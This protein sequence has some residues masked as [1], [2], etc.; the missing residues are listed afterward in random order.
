MDFLTR[1]VGELRQVGIPVSMVE[2]IDAAQ[3][4][5]HVDLESRSMVKAAL[6]ATLVKS[7]R[8][9]AAFETAFEAYFSLLGPAPGS[10]EAA[11]RRDADLA[12]MTGSGSTVFGL[13]ANAETARQAGE[14]V[15][16]KF[17]PSMWTTVTQ[18]RTGG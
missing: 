14:Q 7:A 12:L 3:A 15:R 2:A 8:H 4:L 17:G 10:E 11:V 1:F 6:G 18:I 5:E 13:F 9:V 16:V